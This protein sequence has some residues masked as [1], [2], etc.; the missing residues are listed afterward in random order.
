M[1]TSD[2]TVVA[3]KYYKCDTGQ[4]EPVIRAERLLEQLGE[5]P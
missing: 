5:G 4:Q 1:G 2:R 3:R